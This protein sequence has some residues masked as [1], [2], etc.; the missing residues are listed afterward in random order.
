M[1]KEHSHPLINL[2]LK[3]LYENSDKF[4]Y[5]DEIVIRDSLKSY[6]VYIFEVI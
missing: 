2:R 3:V 5:R 6:R 1:V 4:I